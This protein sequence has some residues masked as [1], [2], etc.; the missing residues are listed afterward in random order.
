MIWGTHI[1]GN[2]HM[3]TYNMY[4]TLQGVKQVES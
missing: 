2:L 3:I 4:Q 1:L